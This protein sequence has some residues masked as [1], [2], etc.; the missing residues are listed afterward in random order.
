MNLDEQSVG[1][2]DAFGGDAPGEKIRPVGEDA[3]RSGPERTE[4]GERAVLNRKLKAKVD[5]ASRPDYAGPP[6]TVPEEAPKKP[7]VR[8]APGDTG[9]VP[10]AGPAVEPALPH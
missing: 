1:V 5:T 3:L 7:K 4:N 9:P 10:V 6:V 8:T 2:G